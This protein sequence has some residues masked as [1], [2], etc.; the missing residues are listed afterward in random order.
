MKIVVFNSDVKVAVL[1]FTFYYTFQAKFPAIV[2]S[3]V[4]LCN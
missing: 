2:W 1:P 3:K 4:N